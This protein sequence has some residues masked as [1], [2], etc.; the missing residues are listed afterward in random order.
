[1]WSITFKGES[2]LPETIAGFTDKDESVRYAKKLETDARAKR[3][4]LNDPRAERYAEFARKPVP[5]HL[6]DFGNF[7]AAKGVTPKHARAKRVILDRAAEACK[8]ESITDIDAAGVSAYPKRLQG[9]RD[10]GTG[11]ELAPLGGLF[12]RQVAERREA[13]EGQSAG[14]RA[15]TGR[16]VGS[17]AGAAGA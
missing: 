9:L 1:M 3:L 15:E 10:R 13:A 12:L 2:G 6:D 14:P 17:G 8:W 7:L 5:E 16:G 4:G 11:R